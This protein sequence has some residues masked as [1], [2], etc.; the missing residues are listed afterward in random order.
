LFVFVTV[1]AQ[2]WVLR[3]LAARSLCNISE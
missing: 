1:A 2:L 3:V